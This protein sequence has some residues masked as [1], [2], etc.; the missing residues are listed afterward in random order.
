MLDACAKAKDPQRALRWHETMLARGLRPNNTTCT[1]LAVALAR[2]G[3]FAQALGALEAMEDFGLQGDAVAYTCLLDACAKARENLY[4]Q[5]VFAL[6]KRRGVQPNILTYTSLARAQG[7]CGRWDKVEELAREMRANY[8]IRMNDFFLYALLLAYAFGR[9]RQTEKAEAAFLFYVKEEQVPINKYI[10]S[11]LSRAVGS[12][13]AKELV[14]MTGYK[15]FRN[16]RPRAARWEVRAPAA[17]GARE[18]R[19]AREDE[20]GQRPRAVSARAAGGGGGDRGPGWLHL[21]RCGRFCG[22]QGVGRVQAQSPGRDACVAHQ[23]RG[24]SADAFAHQPLRGG[25]REVSEKPPQQRHAYVSEAPLRHLELMPT[26]PWCGKC[27]PQPLDGQ[28]PVKP[29]QLAT[30]QQSSAQALFENV[31]EFGT[32]TTSPKRAVARQARYEF[33]PKN[34]DEAV[35]KFHN[36]QPRIEQLG[37]RLSLTATHPMTFFQRTA[38]TPDEIELMPSMTRSRFSSAPFTGYD[39]QM[40]PDPGS[41]SECSESSSSGSDAPPKILT[42]LTTLEVSRMEL[43]TLNHAK[44]QSLIESTRK[45]G[46]QS[47]RARRTTVHTKFA[48]LWQL[49]KRRQ[50]G[51]ISKEENY[52]LMSQ[53]RFL[54]FFSDIPPELYDQIVDKIFTDTYVPGCHL[55]EEGEEADSVFMIITG[56]VKLRNENAGVL[57]HDSTK[58]APCVLLG[59]DVFS[60]WQRGQPFTVKPKE[61]RIR[62]MTAV[63]SGGDMGPSTTVAFSFPVDALECVS[64][65]YRKKEAAD[66]WHIVRS[67]AKSQRLSAQVCQKHQDVF[68]VKGYPRRATC[69]SMPARSLHSRRGTNPLCHGGRA[70]GGASGQEKDKLGRQVGKGKKER[71]GKG[72]LIGDAV[73]YGEPYPSAVVST[74]DVKVLVVK[75]SDYLH[76][77]LNRSVVLPRPEGYQP[78]EGDL[79]TT[80]RR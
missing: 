25:L 43:V 60:N 57:A 27:M 20:A 72:Y 54:P 22:Q 52:Y 28:L 9:P 53:L 56:E 69:S 68:T 35:V 5:K 71:V 36:R 45:E 76:K 62:S 48:S 7:N 67:F 50:D 6:M 19:E 74:S 29:E 41:D 38:E 39:V 44:T 24:H 17:P 15:V 23:R 65:Y 79:A 63:A 26:N 46:V 73:L 13:R 16:R 30:G 78:T 10:I 40:N 37:E 1:A 4:A 18:A 42:R 55:F 32:M 11:G 47:A 64:Q 12:Q 70:A 8:G 66:R 3:D 14:Y 61:D 77:L 34:S 31:D 49:L 33:F 21:G 80:Q 2:A 51:T 58:A 75:A 59:S